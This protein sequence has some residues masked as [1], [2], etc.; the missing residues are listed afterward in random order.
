[1]ANITVNEH[2]CSYE[3]GNLEYNGD[4]EITIVLQKNGR[5]NVR[6]TYMPYFIDVNLMSF[7]IEKDKNGKYGHMNHIDIPSSVRG[8]GLGKLCLAIFYAILREMNVSRFSIKFG[9]G[10]N[11]RKF[12]SSIG[13]SSSRIYSKQKK[14]FIFDSVMVGDFVSTGKRS[15]DW[16]LYPISISEF[17]TGFFSLK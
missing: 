15:S 2:T 12:I 9:G 10:E 11:S 6:S 5:W 8:R 17:P 3:N 13:F 14:P 4:E 16:L 7:M 1:M